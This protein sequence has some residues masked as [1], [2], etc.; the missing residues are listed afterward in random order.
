MGSEHL[1]V[2]HALRASDPFRRFKPE[3]TQEVRKL[4]VTGNFAKIRE[5][6]IKWND[7]PDLRYY[8]GDYLVALAAIEGISISSRDVERFCVLLIEHQDEPIFHLKSGLF[9]SALI[10]SSNDNEFHLSTQHLKERI[11][12]LGYR[13]KKKIIIDGN[14]GFNVGIEMKKGV[15]LVRGDTYDGVGDK[16]EGGS[17]IICG[18]SS[19]CDGIGNNMHG[20]AIL[21]KGGVY[22]FGDIGNGMDGGRITVQGKKMGEYVDD[23]VEYIARIGLVTCGEIHIFCKY[24]GLESVKGGMVYH[25]GK[26]IYP[27]R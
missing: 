24:Y 8:S 20:G 5:A 21:I 11:C 2:S 15:I 25:K 7:H 23:P 13:N 19:G 14:L 6:W 22:E 3:P 9:L 1:A 16:M 10:N 27:N 12:N 26:L 17:I 4:E 18:N